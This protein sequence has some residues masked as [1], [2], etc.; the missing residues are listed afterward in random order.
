MM[1]KDEQRQRYLDRISLGLCT[2]CKDDTKAEPGRRLCAGHV[3]EVRV[4][5]QARVRRAREAG[6]CVDCA[7]PALA[8]YIRC[9]ACLDRRNA[10]KRAWKRARA[11]MGICL[12]C[13]DEAVPGSRFCKE[14]RALRSAASAQRKRDLRIE[15]RVAKQAEE[16]PA[17]RR[18]E[19]ARRA[20]L[21][22]SRELRR[23]SGSVVSSR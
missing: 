18:F 12:E 3:A 1:T 2:R 19:V 14:H 15:K 10:E 17:W 6:R 20:R 8:G 22:A 7:E 11:A 5:R 21:S 23:R 9:R 13:S 4:K 16:V